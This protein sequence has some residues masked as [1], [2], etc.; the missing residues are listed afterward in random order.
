MRAGGLG[1]VDARDAFPAAGFDVGLRRHVDAHV[2]VED[3][4][5]SRQL[6]ELRVCIKVVCVEEKIHV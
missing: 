1:E 5:E 3:E 6:G 4:R 2:V